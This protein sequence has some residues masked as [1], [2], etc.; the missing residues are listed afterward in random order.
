MPFL[1]CNGIDKA[2]EAGWVPQFGRIPEILWFLAGFV[3]DP[4]NIS[5]CDLR[6]TPAPFIVLQGRFNAAGIIFINT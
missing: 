5:I 6:F 1:L 4:G 3:Y 2:R